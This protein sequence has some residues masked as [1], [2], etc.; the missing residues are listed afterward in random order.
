[1]A[2]RREFL[3]WFTPGLPTRSLAEGEVPAPEPAAV[4]TVS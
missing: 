2:I 3:M 4:A 1:M